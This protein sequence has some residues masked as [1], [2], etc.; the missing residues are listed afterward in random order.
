LT[1][2]L[3]LLTFEPKSSYGLKP[4]TL[5]SRS[6]IDASA[7]LPRCRGAPQ[8]GQTREGRGRRRKGI[9][10]ALA[11]GAAALAV[12]AYA[13]AGGSGPGF[14]HLSANLSGYQ[15]TPSISTTGT[16]DFTADVTKDGQ[17][18]SWQL[19]YANLEGNVLQ[20]HIHFGQRG[21]PGG[22]SV[23]LSYRCSSRRITAKPN[24]AARAPSTTRWSNVTET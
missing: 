17:S 23:F 10:A 20:S 15:E 5:A 19:S 14:N 1:P 13:L 6:Q 11:V 22:I 4:F 24:S 9:F 12:A 2:A 18:V 16:A 3:G 7:P 8:S 21:V